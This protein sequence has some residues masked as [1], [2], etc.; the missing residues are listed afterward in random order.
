MQTD[1][2]FERIRVLET[3]H[4]K[5]SWNMA[6]DEVLLKKTRDGTPILRIYGWSNPCVSIGY[7]QSIND[8]DFEFC[9][10]NGIDVVRRITGGGAVFHE[11]ELTYSFTT[12]EF[13]SNILESYQSICQMIISGLAKLGLR[14]KFSPLNDITV[15]GKK[16]CGNAQTRKDETLLQ[17][18]TVLLDVDKQK[19][20][21]VLKIPV[22][23]IQG[24]ATTPHDRVAGVMRSFEE[25]KHAI[26]ESCSEIFE[27]KLEPYE[28]GD[29]E[30]LACSRLIQTKYG[31]KD[32]TTRR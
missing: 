20:F 7:F 17:H 9:L 8:I 11:S 23:K 24:K 6:L 12:K 22:E 14:A 25:V 18:G 32:W 10:Q 13:P 31:T 27:A 21:S 26:K 2:K 19:M 1:M 29:N 30:E 4:K 15:N 16:V 28:I 3:G 5:G